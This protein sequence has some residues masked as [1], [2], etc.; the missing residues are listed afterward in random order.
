MANPSKAM[1]LVA[2]SGMIVGLAAC[3]GST[4]PPDSAAQPAGGTEAHSC[5]GGEASCKANGKC[6]GA[7]EAAPAD[8]NAA[9]TPPADA[10]K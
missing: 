10:P 5:K 9:P 1:A 4:P 6:N 3:G 8:P 7:K 2:V